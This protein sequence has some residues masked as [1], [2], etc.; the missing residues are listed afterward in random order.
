MD[1]AAIKKLAETHLA[2]W[3]EKDRIKRDGMMTTIYA[4][5]IIMY[6]KDFILTGNKEISDFIDKVQ[7]DPVFDFHAIR[8]MEDTQNGA[9]L[10]WSIKTT[11][12]L[13]TGMD[14]LILENDL[15]DQIYVF[16]DAG[17]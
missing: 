6:D 7:G 12:G 17:N 9:R 3:N 11:Q 4:A 15:V 16:I 2:V 5:D 10:F 1:S 13:L 14:F 8:P